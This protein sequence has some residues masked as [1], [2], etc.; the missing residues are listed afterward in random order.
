MLEALR[1]A[2]G[3]AAEP[4]P[5]L[6]GLRLACMTDTG[7][8][9]PH[10][11]DNFVFLG[12]LMPQE[13]QSLGT[14]LTAEVTAD[15]PT[16]V[17]VLDG[18]GGELAGEAASYAAALALRDAQGAVEPTVASLDGAFRAMQDAVS[19]VR[20][21]ARLSSIG[22]TATV[23]VSQGARALVAN[24]GDSPA[25][26]LRDGSLVT[27]TV[28][29]TDAELLRELGI[30]RRP[31]LTQYLGMDEGDAPIEPHFQPLALEP[32]DRIV[33]ASDGLTDMVGLRDIAQAMREAESPRELVSR[34]CEQ[35]LEAGGADN[36]T[37]IACEAMARTRTG[38]IG[39]RR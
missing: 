25:F 7:R 28:A 11:E 16:C 22:T 18:M 24:L 37:I 5:C 33:L 30:D 17:A 14:V 19:A 38:T 23:L 29:H 8:R 39:R 15:E 3:L 2:L 12:Q 31:G 36:I 27:L 1:Q 13:H 35:A 32:G 9:R 34:L 10:N 26:L 6:M 20:V 21:N 4:E